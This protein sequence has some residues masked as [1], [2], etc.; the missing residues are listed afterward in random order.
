MK[1]TICDK[2]LICVEPCSGLAMNEEYRAMADD[3]RRVMVMNS[4]GDYKYYRT[5]R[6]VEKWER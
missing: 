5:N 3:G 4:N 6:F 1:G 2:S